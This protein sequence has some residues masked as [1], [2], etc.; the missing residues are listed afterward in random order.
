ML[1]KTRFWLIHSFGKAHSGGKRCENLV[2]A[3]NLAGHQDA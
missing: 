3:D 1:A 2:G